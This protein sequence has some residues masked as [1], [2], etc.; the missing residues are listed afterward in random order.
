MD[1]TPGQPFTL[2]LGFGADATAAVGMARA[3]ASTPFVSM[4]DSYVSGWRAYDRA[5]RRPPASVPSSTR[6]RYWTYRSVFARDG[7]E[8]FTGLLADGDLSSARDRRA[9]R[10]FTAGGGRRLRHHGRS[11]AGC[12]CDWMGPGDGQGMTA[13]GLR[14]DR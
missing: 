3:S 12:P 11:G 1:T 9:G 8:T 7:Y 6:A 5:L 14:D 13:N 4:M 10:G 2:A